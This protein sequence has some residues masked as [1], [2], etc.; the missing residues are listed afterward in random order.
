MTI[1]SIIRNPTFMF[2]WVEFYH[3]SLPMSDDTMGHDTLVLESSNPSVYYLRN[4][5]NRGWCSSGNPRIVSHRIH[6]YKR[7]GGGVVQ[8]TSVPP[9]DGSV[10][11]EVTTTTL[12]STRSKDFLH[13]TSG[14]KPLTSSP[15][16]SVRTV[17][18]EV[19]HHD[20]KRKCM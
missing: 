13:R 2:F 4:P 10:P 5:S 11:E 1:W 6:P 12:K 19:Y 8:F 18:V 3:I 16:T 15:T 20:C 14:S 9:Q 7:S 17:R